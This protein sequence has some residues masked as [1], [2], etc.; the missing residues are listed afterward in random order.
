MESILSQRSLPHANTPIGKSKYLIH[1]CGSAIT[2]LA[3]LMGITPT[4]VNEKLTNNDGY[5][6]DGT[7]EVI[8]VSWDKLGVIFP[9]WSA[10]YIEPYNNETVLDALSK[11]RFIFVLVKSDLVLPGQLHTLRYIGNGK[12]HDPFKGEERPTSDFP[13]VQAMV[14]LTK[15]PTLEPAKIN[16]ET[17]GNGDF[18]VTVHDQVI[19]DA[20]E[21]TEDLPEDE[22]VIEHPKGTQITLANLPVHEKRAILKHLKKIKS[23]TLE[24]KKLLAL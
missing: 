22:E 13:S 1:V 12:C 21:E 8:Q 23:S 16:V 11:E 9:G 19:Q 17:L 5:I 7:G 4:E 20:V 14:V 18:K 10:Q 6:P 15:L 24:I 2:L 3:E